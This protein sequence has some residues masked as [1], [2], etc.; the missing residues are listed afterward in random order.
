MSVL[1]I[2]LFQVATDA[3]GKT[4]TE[5]T[6]EDTVKEKAAVVECQ[7]ALLEFEKPV[8]CLP[9][10]I[11]IGSRLDTDVHIHPAHQSLTHTYSILYT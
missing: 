6:G 4:G 1:F 7:Y 3:T 2:P 9:D 8:T 5:G 10:S 11:A